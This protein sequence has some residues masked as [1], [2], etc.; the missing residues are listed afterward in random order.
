M[1][2]NGNKFSNLLAKFRLPYTT[3]TFVVCSIVLLSVGA[4]APVAQVY[5]LRENSISTGDMKFI[6]SG[7]RPAQRFD[8]QQWFMRT[9]ATA[10]LSATLI[11]LAYVLEKQINRNSGT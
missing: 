3:G 8:Y 4:Y 1:P 2:Q 11:S 7:L 6:L 9:V 5:D 10:F